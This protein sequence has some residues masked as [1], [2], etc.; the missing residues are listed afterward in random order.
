MDVEIKS[1]GGEIQLQTGLKNKLIK[2]LDKI[3]SQILINETNKGPIKQNNS[4]GCSIKW[5][6]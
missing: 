1:I 2:E 6:Q 3:N 4:I 5:K